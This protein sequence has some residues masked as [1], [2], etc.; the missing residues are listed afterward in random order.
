MHEE[1][2]FEILPATCFNATFIPLF[3]FFL[4]RSSCVTPQKANFY[5]NSVFFLEARAGK[6]HRGSKNESQLNE[7][8]KTKTEK[9]TEN[10]PKTKQVTLR[11][12]FFNFFFYHGDILRNGRW[13]GFL[14]AR[15]KHRIQDVVELFSR[16]RQQE[17]EQEQEEQGGVK[18]KE[19]VHSGTE[20]PLKCK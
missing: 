9:Q 15:E 1:E 7:A 18:T 17:Q 19:L 3:F 11:L 8:K 4:Q 5:S 12:I 2:P 6:H 10:N 20:S 14:K 16:Q 13:I